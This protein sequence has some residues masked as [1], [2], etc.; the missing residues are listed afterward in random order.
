MSHPKISLRRFENRFSR[1]KIWYVPGDCRSFH[2]DCKLRRKLFIFSKV[3]LITLSLQWEIWYVPGDCPSFHQDCNRVKTPYFYSNR[4]FLL[5]SWV[6]KLIPL[7]F[8]FKM[9]LFLLILFKNSGGGELIPLLVRVKKW[10]MPGDCPSFHQDWSVIFSCVWWGGP[11]ALALK[12]RAMSVRIW[13]GGGAR[14]P[15][16]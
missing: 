8:L 15:F 14:R 13:P 6:G 1:L 2:Q 9:A 3:K 12:G 11:G 7:L 16:K 10:Y 4:Q 5:S